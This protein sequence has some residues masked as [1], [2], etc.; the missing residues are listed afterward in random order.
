MKAIAVLA[1]VLAAVAWGPAMARGPTN[2]PT[3]ARASFDCAKASSPIELAICAD[4]ALAA[5]DRRVA[6]SYAAAR[7][8]APAAWREPLRESQRSWLTSMA[9]TCVPGDLAQREAGATIVSCRRAKFDER[10]RALEHTMH[11]AGGFDFVELTTYETHPAR[12][13]D[14]DL[15]ETPWSVQTSIAA[16]QIASPTTPAQRQW[17][18]M[19]GGRQRKVVADAEA[20]FGAESSIDIDAVSADLLQ[21]TIRVETDGG[22]HGFNVENFPVAW[23]LRL[24]RGLEPGDV[25]IN[26]AAAKTAL[27]RLEMRALRKAVA[28]HPDEPEI[29]ASEIA[30]AVT[31]PRYWVWDREGLWFSVGDDFGRGSSMARLAETIPWSALRP[32]LRKDLPFDPAALKKPEQR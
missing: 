31:S 26:P 14:L 3:S 4:P 27:V 6:A 16:L 32:Y 28:G 7:A 12:K 19:I 23:S 11:H 30:R 13:E 21:A 1:A 10:V 18:S 20:V 5:A 2:L 9:G 29:I 17:N 8:H 22:P 24:G 25:F 15:G